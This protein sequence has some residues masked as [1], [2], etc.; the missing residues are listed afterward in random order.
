MKPIHSPKNNATKLV[1]PI[2][3][4]KSPEKITDAQLV[5]LQLLNERAKRISAEQQLAAQQYNA[6]TTA[7]KSALA[8]NNAFAQ[9]LHVVY[10]IVGNDQIS[11]ES[12]KIVRAPA[13]KVGKA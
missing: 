12:G 10:K 1:P 13:K 3:P 2:A 6:T 8:E 9:T 5:R 11:L 7:L 4:I